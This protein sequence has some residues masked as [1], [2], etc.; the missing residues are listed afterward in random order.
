MDIKI[1]NFINNLVHSIPQYIKSIEVIN[2]EISIIISSNNL[3]KVL[4]YLKKNTNMQMTQML[5]ITAVDLLNSTERFVIIYQLL[6]LRFNQRLVIKVFLEKNTNSIFSETIPSITNIYKSAGWLEREVWAMFGIF[7]S[8]HFDLR[9]ILTDYGF[10]GFPLRKD[11]PI[12]GFCELRYDDEL[13][14]VFYESLE[15]SQEFRF[16]DF[17]SP[18]VSFENHFYK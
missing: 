7:F 5:D 12:S 13:K 2:N 10:Q 6:S 3:L 14:T 4:N 16:F 11:F 1:I 8:G 15:L 18:W 17:Q 9:R